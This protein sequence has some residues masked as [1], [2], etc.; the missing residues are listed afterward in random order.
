MTAGAVP[1][2][3]LVGG[4]WTAAGNPLNPQRSQK[5][6][7]RIP[8]AALKRTCICRLVRVRGRRRVCAAGYR[9]GTAPRAHRASFT[10]S[11]IASMTSSGSSSST[12]WPVSARICS[13]RGLRRTSPSGPG[14]VSNRSALGR[15]G[16]FLYRFGRRLGVMIFTGMSPIRLRSSRRPLNLKEVRFSTFS[17]L[18]ATVASTISRGGLGGGRGVDEDEAGDRR[19]APPHS[20]PRLAASTGPDQHDG[21]GILA[22]WTRRSRSR[23]DPTDRADPEPDRSRPRSACRTRMSVSPSRRVVR[24]NVHLMGS[25]PRPLP[26]SPR[27]GEP[28]RLIST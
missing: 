26:S 9:L 20:P 21:G 19:D 4:H 28:S 18:D 23:P 6:R 24:A 16:R 14:L 12:E 27:S 1:S 5:A 7:V 8:S 17:G 10:A 15:V 2:A 3:G 13:A 11:R 22:T 25:R